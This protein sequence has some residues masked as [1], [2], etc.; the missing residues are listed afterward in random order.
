MSCDAMGNVGCGAAATYV[1]RRYG[2][3]R[4]AG[5]TQICTKV[6]LQLEPKQSTP[7]SISSPDQLLA[8][9]SSHNTVAVCPWEVDVSTLPTIRCAF[10]WQG[11][12]LPDVFVGV[13]GGVWRSI[14]PD[15]NRLGCS[16]ESCWCRHWCYCC[17]CIGHR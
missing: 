2:T 3:V 6:V 7:S 1:K 16:T 13:R 12:N 9:Q 11:S 10:R 8:Q 17:P 14:L 15:H 5:I 4:S